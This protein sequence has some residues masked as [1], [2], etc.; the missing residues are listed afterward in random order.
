MAYR[1]SNQKS[2]GFTLIELLVVIAIMG[3][4]LALLLPA[5]QQARAAARQSQCANNL[6]QLGLALANYAES[7]RVYPAAAEGGL[8]YV[9]MNFTGYSMLLPFVE[10]EANYSQ[11]NFDVSLWGG[12]PYY[13]WTRQ[14]NTTAYGRTSGT[15]LCPAN[16]NRAQTPFVYYA[17]G[18][19]NWRVSNPAVTDYLFSGGASTSVAAPYADNN[20]RGPFGFGFNTDPGSMIDGTSKTILMGESAGGDEANKFYA[21]TG[22]YG[23]NRRCARLDDLSVSG[24][25]VLHYDN[26]MYMAYGRRRG[27]GPN[28]F[29]LGGLVARSVDR[30]GFYY[31]PNDCGYDSRTDA[32]AA[33][34]AQDL[35]NFRSV[36]PG[37]IQAVFADGSVSTISDNIDG[38]IM[39][40]LTTVAGGELNN[41]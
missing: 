29:T 41:R 23:P 8:G 16:R 33:P 25:A 31:R 19:E 9:Y 22:L 13:G 14:E 40:G 3:V 21:L 17:F 20:K 30:Q 18:T 1:L 15:F 6:K 7:H 11:F 24:G 37:L 27:I 39:M 38:N 32:F 36:H 12:A 4:L 10:Q 34:G 28:E 35:P 5:V 2:W 26:L